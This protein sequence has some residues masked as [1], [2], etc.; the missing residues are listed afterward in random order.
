MAASTTTTVS[1]TYNGSRLRY[2]KS[3]RRRHDPLYEYD[4][5]I[6]EVNG[7]TNAQIA[8]NVYGTD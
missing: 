6:L 2:G 7:A 4:R 8:A 5:V 1:Y 3:E